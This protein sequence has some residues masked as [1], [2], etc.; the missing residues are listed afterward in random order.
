MQY[1]ILLYTKIIG[2]K[3]SWIKRNMIQFED[4][5]HIKHIYF[6]SSIILKMGI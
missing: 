6:L 3:F 1:I 4:I 2:K 5:N